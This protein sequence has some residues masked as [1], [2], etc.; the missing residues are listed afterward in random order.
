MIASQVTQ[1]GWDR[2]IECRGANVAPPLRVQKCLRFSRRLR[3]DRRPG[4]PERQWGTIFDQRHAAELCPLATSA[5]VP[6]RTHG[7][8]GTR[9]W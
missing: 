6:I 9:I 5:S 3:G 7:D 4:R 2:T 1:R 8:R